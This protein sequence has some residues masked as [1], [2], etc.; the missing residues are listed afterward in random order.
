[1]GRL[2]LGYKGLTIATQVSN[3]IVLAFVGLYFFTDV[4]DGEFRGFRVCVMPNNKSV[5]DGSITGFLGKAGLLQRA[6]NHPQANAP[7]ERR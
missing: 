3:W 2:V 6:Q 1:V 5:D 7:P 4:L